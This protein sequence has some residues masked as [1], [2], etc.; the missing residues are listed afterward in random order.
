MNNSYDKLPT[1]SVFEIVKLKGCIRS[2]IGEVTSPVLIVH[3]RFD[4]VAPLKNV[5]LLKSLLCSDIVDI[6]ILERS[7]HVVSLDYDK[8]EAAKATVAFLERFS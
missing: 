4:A 2:R 5:E 6:V 1:P 8:Q 7:K 3:G